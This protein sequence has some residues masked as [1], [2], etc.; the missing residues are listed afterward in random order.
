MRRILVCVAVVAFGAA[1]GGAAET[2][3]VPMNAW[4]VVDGDSTVAG[5][6]LLLLNESAVEATVNSAVGRVIVRAQSGTERR[7][8]VLTHLALTYDDGAQETCSLR[9]PADTKDHQVTFEPKFARWRRVV[10]LKLWHPADNM[11]MRVNEVAVV[12]EEPDMLLTD[13]LGP[14]A[15]LSG[16]AVENRLLKVKWT[17]GG[18]EAQIPSPR[19]RQVVVFG[20]KIAKSEWGLES[21]EELI[22]KAVDRHGRTLKEYKEPL[23]GRVQPV[24]FYLYD[25]DLA[26]VDRLIF[27]AEGTSDFVIRRIIDGSVGVGTPQKQ[28][29]DGDLEAVNDRLEIVIDIIERGGDLPQSVV[30]QLKQLL[31]DYRRLE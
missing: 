23:N 12:A 7:Q 17:A 14:I 25:L 4:Q 19:S 21:E 27:E 13:E 16:E 5:D 11:Q 9:V 28:K 10:R 24:L 3:I 31:L 6:H 18:P 8:S 20:A 2:S 30:W 1:V 22:L 15:T 29:W 26:R